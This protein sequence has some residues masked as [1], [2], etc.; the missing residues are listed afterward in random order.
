MMTLITI[1]L[2]MHRTPT[3]MAGE[4]VQSETPVQ[5]PVSGAIPEAENS[6]RMT[7]IHD[8]KPILGVGTDWQ[9]LYWMLAALVLLVLLA[10]AR[11]WWKRRRRRSE[12]TAAAP[13]V[14]AEEEA[15]GAL[16][17]L[18][19][20]NAMTPKQFYFRLSAILRRYM[21]RRFE[22]PAAEMTTEEL[23]PRVDQLSL[24]QSL[25]GQFKALCLETDP[26]KFAGV[27]AR[28][29]RPAQDLAFAR[30]FVRRTTVS[31]TASDSNDTGETPRLEK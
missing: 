9:W 14:P 4:P 26:V 22:F 11:W 16:D 25:A 29:G 10:L 23:L 13:P 20:E 28:P 31:I 2:L 1:G 21:E 15:Y 5:P 3:A 17:A 8:I 27:D 19:A 6:A 30:D 18:A 7:D 12:R 24:E